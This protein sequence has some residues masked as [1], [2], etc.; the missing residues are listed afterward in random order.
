MN[1]HSNRRQFLGG[2]AA[3]GALSLTTLPAMGCS[4][5]EVVDELNTLLSSAESV[6]NVAEPGA[7]WVVE[8]VAAVAALKQAEASWQSGSAVTIVISALNTLAAVAA[9]VP[10][11]A[12]YSPLIDVLVAGIDAVLTALPVSLVG[13]AATRALLSNP[14]AGRVQLKKPHFMQSKVGAYKH[15]WNEI[16][17]AIPALA[18]ARI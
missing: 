6:L 14:R 15:Q 17:D 4:G 3:A 13:P 16:V 2:L 7:P 5:S 10:L 9:V 12:L 11:T 8:F 1:I 18:N